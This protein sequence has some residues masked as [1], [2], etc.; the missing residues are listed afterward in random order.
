M[1]VD[2]HAEVAL[3]DEFARAFE[4]FR[5]L[6][7]RD[8]INALQPPGPAAIY[9][10]FVVV[11]LLVY[12]RL[13]ANASLRDA[14]AELLRSTAELPRQRRIIEQTLSSNTGAYSR[15]RSRLDVE[16]ALHVADHVYQTLVDVTPPAW[17]QR[18]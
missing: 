5:S 4:Q 3:A 11:W 7:D 6:I 8:A 2:S 18:R 13:H 10:P 9:T 1:A 12:Q 14:V 15:A 17:G 16:V